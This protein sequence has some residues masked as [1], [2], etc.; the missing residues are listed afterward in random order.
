M[1]LKSI[2]SSTS[3]TNAWK[4]WDSWPFQDLIEVDDGIS[5]AWVETPQIK[6]SCIVSLQSNDGC[7]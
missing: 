1:K 7:L 3:S 6:R 2:T 4:C 5:M